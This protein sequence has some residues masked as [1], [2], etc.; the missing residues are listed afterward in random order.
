[1]KWEADEFQGW[2]AWCQRYPST[3]QCIA[4]LSTLVAAVAG[5]KS[6][7]PPGMFGD[8][9]GET[10]RQRAESA[11]KKALAAFKALSIKREIEI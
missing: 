3:E 6:G 2:Y 8:W 9:W 7:L 1:M 5:G 11:P 4:A 10:A